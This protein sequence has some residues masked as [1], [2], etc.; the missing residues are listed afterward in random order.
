MIKGRSSRKG[1]LD[2][3]IN[4]FI[5]VK[6]WQKA[7]RFEVDDREEEEIVDLTTH[8]FPTINLL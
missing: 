2:T 4:G 8:T 6:R 1:V 5:L 3:A 7:A